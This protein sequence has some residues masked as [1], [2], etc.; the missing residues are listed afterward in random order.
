MD[1]FAPSRFKRRASS[2]EIVAELEDSNLVETMFVT[3][4]FS[5][6]CVGILEW[7][8]QIPKMY[9][10]VVDNQNLCENFRLEMVNNALSY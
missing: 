7:Q 6:F 10:S 3:V 8:K 1:V 2:F 9:Y 4:L 5:L